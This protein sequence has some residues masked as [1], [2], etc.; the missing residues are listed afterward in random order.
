[1]SIEVLPAIYLSYSP[2]LTSYQMCY[3]PN[4]IGQASHTNGVPQEIWLFV[5][6]QLGGKGALKCMSTH[7]SVKTGFNPEE[8]KK[9]NLLDFNVLSRGCDKDNQC[10]GVIEGLIPGYD[11]AISDKTKHI[12]DLTIAS[13]ESLAK[14]GPECTNLIRLTHVPIAW[15][16]YSNPKLRFVCLQ[17]PAT[18]NPFMIVDALGTRPELME[19][20]VSGEVPGMPDNGSPNVTWL[21]LQRI[22]ERC[23]SLKVLVMGGNIRSMIPLEIASHAVTLDG[24][25]NTRLECLNLCRIV[26]WD[27]CDLGILLPRCP[28]LK[29]LGLPSGTSP[30]Q[31]MSIATAISLNC[32]RL[33]TVILQASPLEFVSFGM[34]LASFQTLANLQMLFCSGFHHLMLGEALAKHQRSLQSVRIDWYPSS[35]EHFRTQMAFLVA[36][37]PMRGECTLRRY[38]MEWLSVSESPLEP[39]GH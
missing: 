10:F 18:Y 2:R 30:G 22:F 34:F 7:P 32:R 38:S 1:M 29:R 39:T 31:L 8:W 6:E 15:L 12:Q 20:G 13:P 37:L 24:F 4:N 9:V 23:L 17:I 35:D 33:H 3:D 26:P 11:R 14:L 27:G 19:L 36:Y 28:N 5:A 16:K 21:V 25:V